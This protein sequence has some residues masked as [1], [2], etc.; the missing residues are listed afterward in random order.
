VNISSSKYFIGV[1]N[2]TQSTKTILL[3]S[4]TGLVVSKAAKSYN[5]LKDL[6]P[7]YKE[8]DP[9]DWIKAILA[10]IKNVLE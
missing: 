7:G 8:Q 3:D 6:P 4:D 5:L 1:D 2:G 10:T 9:A